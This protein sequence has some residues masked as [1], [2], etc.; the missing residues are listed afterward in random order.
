MDTDSRTQARQAL[1][2]VGAL[3]LGCAVVGLLVWLVWFSPDG[4]SRRELG[5]ARDT[6]ESR[7][8]SSYAFDYVHCGGMCAYCPVRV[9]VVDGV[10]GDAVR[11][12]DGCVGGAVQDAP[13]IDDLLDVAGQHRRT[14]FRDASVTYD[15]RWGYPTL[16]VER[17]PDGWND[18]GSSWVVSGFEVLAE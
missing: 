15:A 5:R 8:P 16:V 13:T 4:Q 9:T 3:V 10:V 11:T 14:F 12:G 2:V 18:C 7:A 17:C 1:E 6:W